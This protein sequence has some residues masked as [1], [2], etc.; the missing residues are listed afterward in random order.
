VPT[1]RESGFPNIVA[2]GWFGAYAPARTPE[3]A[4]AAFNRAL[5]RALAQPDVVERFARLALE[6]GGGTPADLSR[7]EQASTA[8]WAPVV[9]ATGFRAD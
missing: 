9:K 2:S 4:I 6:P 3:P 1:F 8:R 7:I 5:N